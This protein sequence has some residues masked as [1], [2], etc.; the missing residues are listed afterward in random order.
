MIA[1]PFDS[2]A[3]IRLGLLAEL[4]DGDN[5]AAEKFYLQAAKLDHLFAP[6]WTLANFYFR[7]QN[8]VKFFQWAKE[9]LAIT[10]NDSE[11]LFAQMWL[12]SQNPD[13][14]N[15]TILDRRRVLLQY[16]RYLTGAK[17]F[18]SIPPVVKRIVRLSAKDDVGEW[19]RNDLL[20]DS[21]DKMLS[22][23]SAESRI[24][25][26]LLCW[27]YGREK[28][29]PSLVAGGLNESALEEF[30]GATL[31]NAACGT[32]YSAA[33]PSASSCHSSLALGGCL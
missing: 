1:N 28:S 18:D 16:A 19:E 33:R 12:M 4:Q 14:L 30:L 7:Q 21:L 15:E 24:G 3:W 27:N 22:A 32:L 8:P 10:S 23:G 20:A 6:K 11:P 5:A 17:H 9:T 13:Q 2:N 25:H 26:P 31:L 29:Y